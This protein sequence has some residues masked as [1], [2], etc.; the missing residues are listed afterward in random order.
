MV[1]M[2]LYY[3]DVG[4]GLQPLPITFILSDHALS[5]FEWNK[6]LCD[7]LAAANGMDATLAGMQHTVCYSTCWYLGLYGVLS[8]L[9]LSVTT[10]E[11]R[12]LNVQGLLEMVEK[13]NMMVLLMNEKCCAL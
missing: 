6:R 13:D 8:S 9:V 11:N 12:P 5:M 10:C 7:D 1:F 4:Q 3:V 2:S